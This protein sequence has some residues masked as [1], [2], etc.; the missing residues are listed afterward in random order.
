M[1]ARGEIGGGVP[2]SLP[3]SAFSK[4]VD[5]I[6]QAPAAVF[7]IQLECFFERVGVARDESLD[8]GLVLFRRRCQV[9][10]DRAGVETPVALGLRLDGAMQRH[11]PWSGAR[12][13]DQAMKLAVEI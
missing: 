4:N 9:M 8:D 5:H 2:G 6:C 3:A 13:N 11:Q 10:D 7:P 12:V 1:T